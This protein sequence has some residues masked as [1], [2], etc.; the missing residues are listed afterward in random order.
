MSVNK[1]LFIGLS[2]VGDVVMTTP[3]LKSLQ[4][5]FPE[6]MFDIVVDK[7]GTG[8]YKNYPRLDKLYLKDKDLPL[9]GVPALLLQLWKNRYDLIVDVRT[10]GLAYLLRAKKRY[11][12]W[13]AKSYGPHAVEDLMGVIARLHG[14]N[15]IPDT[16]VWPSD[17]D[18]EYAEKVISQFDNKNKLL[19]IS[20]GDNR[21]PEKT[22]PIEKFIELLNKHHD[23][24]SGVIFLGNSFEAE[25]TLDVAR[26]ININN[27][28][29]V[30]NSLL[31]AAALIEKA[32][33]YIGP[34]SGLGHIAGAVDTPTISFFSLMK[35]ERYR[36]WGKKAIC[37]S[38]SENDARN[39][40]VEEV[41]AAIRRTIDE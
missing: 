2:S 11:T 32:C 22:W 1:I 17:V 29:T 14:N 41:S 25:E 33:L 36:P 40:P 28:N 13:F 21:K 12:K 38:G 8:L 37:I 7:R 15:P 3:V 6:A 19:A 35:P 30:G 27:I 9:R 16:S 23:D 39:I 31:E 24:F 10:D 20:I 34:D 26:K 4:D 18:R 5:K